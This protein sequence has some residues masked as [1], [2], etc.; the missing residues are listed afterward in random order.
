MPLIKGGKYDS[1]KNPRGRIAATRYLLFTAA[2][3][4]SVLLLV[5][6]LGL[7]AIYYRVT[8]L[9]RMMGG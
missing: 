7:Y 8:D 3:I 2:T 9:R 1:V 6:T 4:M 5:A